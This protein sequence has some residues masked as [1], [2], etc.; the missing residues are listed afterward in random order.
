MNDSCNIESL[1]QMSARTNEIVL[2]VVYMVD[3]NIHALITEKVKFMA[4]ELIRM[5]G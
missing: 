2:E 1:A 4:Q 5:F 3:N